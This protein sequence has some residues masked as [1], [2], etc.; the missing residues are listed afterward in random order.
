M[1]CFALVWNGPCLGN[2]GAGVVC[3]KGNAGCRLVPLSSNLCR[4]PKYSWHWKSNVLSGMT[5]ACQTPCPCLYIFSSLYRIS[6]VSRKP[7]T[8]LSLVWS[9]IHTTQKIGSR[10]WPM[11]ISAIE[12][13]SRKPSVSTARPSSRSELSAP[14]PF[15]RLAIPVWTNRDSHD[16]R[17][18]CYHGHLWATCRG[19]QGSSRV[20]II[21]RQVTA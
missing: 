7:A 13:I 9:S 1:G 11:C 14:F 3:R 4:H 18:R 8:N 16:G 5:N 12:W 21:K 10:I 20:K 17:C 19:L 6:S 15:C 2:G